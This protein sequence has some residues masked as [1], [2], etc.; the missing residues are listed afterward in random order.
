MEDIEIEELDSQ[1]PI[2]EA[3]ED[4]EV[5]CGEAFIIADMSPSSVFFL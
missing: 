1:E 5:H 4:E 2:Y 3:D